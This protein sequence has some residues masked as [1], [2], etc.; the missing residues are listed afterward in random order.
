MLCSSKF[1]HKASLHLRSMS[2]TM[3]RKT[4]SNNDKE[5]PLSVDVYLYKRA[6]IYTKILSQQ[7]LPL[8]VLMASCHTHTHT[9]RL[10]ISTAEI[11]SEFL[12]STYRSDAYM[13]DNKREN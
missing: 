1:P 12:A 13:H 3:L 9:D 6:Q 11:Y 4:W 7:P 8:S 10:F 2:P 5:R